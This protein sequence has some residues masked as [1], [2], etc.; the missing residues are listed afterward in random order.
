[1]RRCGGVAGA[2]QQTRT[3]GFSCP[4]EGSLTTRGSSTQAGA[5]RC[6]QRKQRTGPACLT[7][8]SRAKP[9]NEQKRMTVQTPTHFV[10]QT[11]STVGLLRSLSARW[12]A[13]G[14]TR[15]VCERLSQSRA[16]GAARHRRDWLRVRQRQTGRA[17]LMQPNELQWV[18]RQAPHNDMPATAWHPVLAYLHSCA[19]FVC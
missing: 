3:P 4:A 8:G 7:G 18:N 6:D 5:P 12:A 13:R 16:H 9:Q 14:G 19:A 15:G 17:R 1:M 10:R 2:E 11:S